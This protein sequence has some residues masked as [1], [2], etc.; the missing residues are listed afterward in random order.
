MDEIATEG[1]W[2]GMPEYT[3]E[4]VELF[5]A[6]DEALMRGEEPDME[7]FLARL[8]RY[9]HRLRPILETT[10]WLRSELQ[11]IKETYPGLRAWH[12]IGLPAKCRP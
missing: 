11:R 3:E 9:A 8:P 5:A 2:K 1:F 4:E 7:A 12:L 10:R 6:Y